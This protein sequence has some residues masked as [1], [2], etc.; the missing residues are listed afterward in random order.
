MASGTSTQTFRGLSWHLYLSNHV[1]L[2]RAYSSA[3]VSTAALQCGKTTSPTSRRYNGLST[4]QAAWLQCTAEH[5]RA[6][7]VGGTASR[8]NIVAACKYCNLHRH[9]SKFAPDPLQY[10][11]RVLK[12]IAQGKWFTG[13]QRLSVRATTPNPRAPR[14]ETVALN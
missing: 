5:L 10:K 14:R 7:H 4:R 12:R 11:S 8:S 6:E 1:T 9:R 2:L 13:I 3:S